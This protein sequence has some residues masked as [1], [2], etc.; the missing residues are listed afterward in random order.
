M[1][2]LLGAATVKQLSS[3]PSQPG[4]PDTACSR[5]PGLIHSLSDQAGPAGKL[6]VPMLC[7]G[8]PSN[9]NVNAGV[10]SLF[11]LANVYPIQKQKQST[12]HAACQRSCSALIVFG[13]W[14]SQVEGSA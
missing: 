13:G 6:P 11:T 14:S 10:R 5:I 2:P 12:N 3:G 7:S 1:L 8:T 4:Q 9:E